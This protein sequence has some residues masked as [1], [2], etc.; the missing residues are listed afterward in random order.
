MANGRVIT[1]YSKPWVAK[2]T[3]TGTTVTY[4]DGTALA[5][6]VSVNIAP[7]SSDAVNFYADNILAESVSSLFTGGTATIE[8]DGLKD[9]A[10]TLIMGI[11]NTTSVTATTGVTVTVQLF[12][13][14]QK[15]PYMGFGCVV[16]YMEDGV[17]TYVPVVL[18]KIIFDQEPLEAS[19][20]EENVSFQTTSLTAKVLRDDTAKHVWKK[21]GAGQSSETN[22]ELTVKKLLGIS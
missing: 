14:D 7:D 12:D 19:T 2:Y 13:D 8:V 20:Q 15:A 9:S 22:A 18:P 5:R 16:R 11:A 4:S 10:R 6:G 21:I 17:T 1:G 3:N